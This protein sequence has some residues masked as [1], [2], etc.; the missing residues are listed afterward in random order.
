MHISPVLLMEVIS[1][2][3]LEVRDCIPPCFV[4]GAWKLAHA[5]RLADA[6][7]RYKVAITS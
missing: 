4:F 6:A 2:W 5:R 3:I 1:L 7:Q